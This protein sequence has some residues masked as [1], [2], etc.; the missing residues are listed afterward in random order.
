MLK[1]AISITNRFGS[2][3]IILASGAKV[4][5][6]EWVQNVLLVKE[7]LKNLAD[8]AENFGVELSIEAPHK[9]TLT[10]NHFQTANFFKLIDDSR[11]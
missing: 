1:K 9:N 8:Y 4:E 2:S 3:K 10:E 6:S 7:H 11:I 5:K